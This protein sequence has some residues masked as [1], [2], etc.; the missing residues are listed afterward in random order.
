MK[1]HVGTS[2]YTA[3]EIYGYIR[4]IKDSD[5][6][7]SA[8]DI[9]S[10]GCIVFE[11]FAEK[12][13]FSLSDSQVLNKYCGE[14]S[15]LPSELLELL[16]DYGTSSSA[17]KFVGELLK[18]DPSERPSAATAL[19]HSWIQGKQPSP[20]QQQE[21]ESKEDLLDRD[22]SSRDYWNDTDDET[23]TK[24]SS[25]RPGFNDF[26]QNSRLLEPMIPPTKLP[27]T[28]FYTPGRSSKLNGT[29]EGKRRY[30]T[31]E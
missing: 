19:K 15:L 11:M 28:G 31:R 1:T 5:E 3:P 21:E 2:G 17:I 7:T 26:K 8:V 25:R 22:N 16:Q 9:W 23:S 30:M 29:S 20:E 4:P 13:P 14:K 27:E 12:P 18:A 24:Y 6:Y 10:L